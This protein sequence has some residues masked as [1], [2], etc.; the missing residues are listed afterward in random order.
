MKLN[1]LIKFH[2]EPIGIALTTVDEIQTGKSFL[3][4]GFEY[5]NFINTGKLLYGLDI[6]T[7]IPKPT[8]EQEKASAKQ[9]LRGICSTINTPSTY[10]SEQNKDTIAYQSFSLIF[11]MARTALCGEGRYVS[12]KMGT[13]SAFHELYAQE[14]KLCKI[15]SQNYELWK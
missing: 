10:A 6:K 14:T 5:H 9:A 13:T 3:G 15:I 4:A 2:P 7:L 12:G 8:R 1:D 11:R